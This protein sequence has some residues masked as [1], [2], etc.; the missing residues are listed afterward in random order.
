MAKF[1]INRGPFKNYVI[2]LGGKGGHQKIT[3]DHK[4]GGEELLEMITKERGVFLES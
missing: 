3:E 4:R 2:L 1:H